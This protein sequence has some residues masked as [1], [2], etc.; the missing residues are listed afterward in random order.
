MSGTEQRLR[1]TQPRRQ[2]GQL[3]QY[4][5]GWAAACCLGL[6]SACSKAADPT[7]TS[8]GTTPKGAI[9]LPGITYWNDVIR[10][11]P[12]SV[13]IVKIDR[14]RKDLA[15]TTTIARNTVVGLA[16]LSAQIR[17]V[18]A[19][20]GKPLV[21]INGDF[22]SVDSGPYI[23]DPRGIQ[24]MEGEYL[25]T[26]GDQS[27]F[28][29][30]AQGNPEIGIVESKFTITW[31]D[32]TVSAARL[33]EER[34]PK[35]TVVF[36]PRLGSSTRTSGGTEAIL[37][38]AGQ[39]PLLPLQVGK[40]VVGKVESIQQGGDTPLKPGK[41]VVSFGPRVSKASTL[42][43]GDV[44]KISPMTEPSLAG[45]RTALGGGNIIVHK[46]EPQKFSMPVSGAYKFRSVVER[47][48]RS[49]VGF[50]DTHIFLVQVDGR[51]GDLS[52]GMTLEELGAYMQKLGCKEAMNFDGGSSST[53]WVA[54]RVV[55]SPS[56]GSERDIG[57]ALVLTQKPAAVS[58]QVP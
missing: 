51:Q 26:P 2:S 33:N 52:I 7:P 56:S 35:E 19:T 57:N 40:E 24:I 43:A 53:L 17:S 49:A 36:T 22:Y 50:S 10:K 15:F 23:G 3:R 46:G 27:V 5:L 48:P 30:D 4:A 31:P 38:A 47:H 18:P 32:G 25:S 55:N 1:E 21:A 12:W 6:L 28:R 34:S 42:K 11:V 14:T 58:Q 44:L 9:Q 13:H 41:L 39:E 45:A 37:V 29:I 54:G 16:Q 20:V 8:G